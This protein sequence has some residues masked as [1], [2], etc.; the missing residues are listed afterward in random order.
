MVHDSLC[1]RL[2]FLLLFGV[3]K[4]HLK[5]AIAASGKQSPPSSP[6]PQNGYPNGQFGLAIHQNDHQARRRFVEWAPKR[7]CRCS[8]WPSGIG[9]GSWLALSRVRAQYH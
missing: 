7:D 2:S 1:E 3:T 9:I 4:R 5:S 8:R 6:P